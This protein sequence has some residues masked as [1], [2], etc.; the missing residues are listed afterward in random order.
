MTRRRSLRPRFSPPP[1]FVAL[2]AFAALAALA[3]PARADV[4]LPNVIGSHMVLQRESQVS[5][6]G[7]ADPG[8]V[9][10]IAPGWTKEKYQVETGADGRFLAQIGTPAAGG[11]FKIT[12]KG[13]NTIELDDVLVGEVWLCGGQSNMEWAFINGNVLDGE[14][15]RAAADDPQLRLCDAPN[16]ASIVPESDAALE[17]KPCTPESVNDFSCVG[18]FFA[19]E[20]RRELKVPVGLIGVNWGGTVAEAWVSAEGLAAFPQFKP[21][22]D[23]LAK[24]H[25]AEVAAGG[26]QKTA[27]NPTAQWWA[28]LD[29]E[30]L[31]TRNGWAA[32]G[33][34]DGGWES[35]RVPA[36]WSGDLSNFDGIAWYRR[37]FEIPAELAGQS[38]DLSLGAI[39]DMDQCFLDGEKIGATDTPGRWAEPRHYAI[40]EAR[41][42]AGRHVLAVRV[43]DTAGQ[44]GWIGKPEEVRLA[45]AKGGASLPL[46]GEW[47]L[48]V[49]LDA[50]RFP[51]VPVA[52]TAN[53]IDP[54][55][56]TVL[57]NGL[58]NP[59]VPF[60]VRGALWYQGESNRGRAAE[61]SDLMPALI[62]DWRRGFERDFPFLFVQ[63]A[64]YNYDGTR[65][66]TAEI[67]QA[68][69]QTLRVPN[70]GMV[71]TMDI[72]DPLNI[73]P[74]NKQ[75]VGRRLSLWALAKTYGRRDVEYS[76]PL[77]VLATAEGGAMRVKFEHAEGLN[78]QGGP[79]RLFEVAGAD[80]KFAPAIAK[81]DGETVVV[82]SPVVKE[83]KAVRFGFTD[84]EATNL[85]NGAGLPASPFCVIGANDVK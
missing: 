6:W 75:E 74:P 78:S 38:L 2:A 7:F 40:A 85:F 82:A 33:F 16:R 72:G 25:A 76:G 54:N 57:W 44:G 58:V 43:V 56:P 53:A 13:K 5:L 50:R 68:Q 48:R 34:D 21:A 71:V 42:T 83:P 26:P 84:G 18:Y 66:A 27:A 64:P 1:A 67:R 9:V 63:I 81:I 19:R 29:R 45:V 69:L 62:A 49:G 46:A 55:T 32:A 77:F 73:H 41:A 31:G 39:D 17:W 30:D 36:V 61:Y 15:E 65:T 51:P 11:P 22:I 4:R 14:K 37:A 60:G 20:L 35:T 8:E 10:T 12:V 28:A 59:I 80:G 3:A 52:A 70:T 79:P 23:R 47:K 24:Q